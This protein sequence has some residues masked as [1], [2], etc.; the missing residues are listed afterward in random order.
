MNRHPKLGEVGQGQEHHTPEE[1]KDNLGRA[2]SLTTKT[3]PFHIPFS[4]VSYLSNGPTINCKCGV[5][6]ATLRCRDLS[7]ADIVEIGCKFALEVCGDMS[8]RSMFCGA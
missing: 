8:S 2:H 7:R 6:L 1:E 3:A 5:V 4:I